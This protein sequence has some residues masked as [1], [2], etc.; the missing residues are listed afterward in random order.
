MFASLLDNY[1]RL[2]EFYWLAAFDQN[3]FH[4][5]GFVGFDLVHHFHR[6]DDAQ[7]VAHVNFLANF[8][9][10]FRVRARRTIES[11]NH[12]ERTM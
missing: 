5:A 8:H 7:G 12:R 10:R 6:F 3:G 9:K 2:V 4:H 1:Q 11:T